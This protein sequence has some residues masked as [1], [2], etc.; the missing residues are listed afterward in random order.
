MK[1]PLHSSISNFFFKCVEWSNSSRNAKKFVFDFWGGPP[2]SDENEKD[3]CFI[4]FCTYIL[5][6]LQNL[7]RF[8]VFIKR[9]VMCNSREVTSTAPLGVARLVTGPLLVMTAVPHPEP[10]TIIS[11]RRKRFGLQLY[12]FMYHCIIKVK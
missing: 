3:S 12:L 7:F 5:F 2:S 11:P 10:I 1:C 6:R 4:L 9:R 8:R